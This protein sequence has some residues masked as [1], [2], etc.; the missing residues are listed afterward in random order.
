MAKDSVHLCEIVTIIF[1]Y[2]YLNSYRSI[3]LFRQLN[4]YVIWLAPF[5]IIFFSRNLFSNVRLEILTLM[6]IAMASEM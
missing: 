3:T 4:I 1:K 6:S 5:K 2:R